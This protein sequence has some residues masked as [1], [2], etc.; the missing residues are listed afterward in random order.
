MLVLASAAALCVAYV[1]DGDSIR[2]CDGERI[3][4]AEIDAP[5][6]PGSPRCQEGGNGWCDYELAVKSRDALEAFLHTGQPIIERVGKDRYGRTLAK[7]LV[8]GEDAGEA[9]K[10]LE[11]AKAYVRR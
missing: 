1:H 8:N 9:L 2:A 7:I 6:M 11:L 10:L 3:R 5:E 4:L